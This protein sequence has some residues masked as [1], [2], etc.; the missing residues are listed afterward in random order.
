[1][2]LAI[3]GSR[4]F[5]DY[6]LMCKVL[7][8]VKGNITVIVSGGA[9]G[10]DRL[11]E[12]YAREHDIELMVIPA[13]WDLLGKSAGFERNKRIVALA[14]AVIAFWDGRSAGTQHTISLA[15]IAKKPVYIKEV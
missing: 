4:T 15:K 12:R 7:G 5:T 10:A 13:E 11:A 8:N 9:R 14:D 6:S 3:V 2:I 1:M